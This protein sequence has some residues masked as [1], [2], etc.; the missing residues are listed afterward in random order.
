MSERMHDK[1]SSSSKLNAM[2]RCPACGADS[3]C[4][5]TS[6]MQEALEAEVVKAASAIQDAKAQEA[7]MMLL[8]LV[9][10]VSRPPRLLDERKPVE[11]P[12][13]LETPAPETLIGMTEEHPQSSHGTYQGTTL[14]YQPADLPLWLRIS[15]NLAAA[16]PGAGAAELS[17]QPTA[18]PSPTSATSPAGP[19]SRGAPA[20][21]EATAFRDWQR[22]STRMTSNQCEGSTKRSRGGSSHQNG[23][24]GGTTWRHDARSRFLHSSWT[25]GSVDTIELSDSDS[26]SDGKGTLT[27]YSDL[28]CASSHELL[29]TVAEEL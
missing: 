27:D 7:V 1:I 14:S 22:L 17:R 24:Q 2:W 12:E 23:A 4:A 8:D 19:L 25:L 5:S 10:L 9:K 20:A 11:A 13:P 15:N 3:S 29:D 6:Y 21:G 16:A 28:A 18:A 26:D